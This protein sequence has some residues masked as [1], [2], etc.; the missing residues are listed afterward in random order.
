MRGP[1]LV[2]D[3]P[4]STQRYNANERESA[5]ARRVESNQ[6]LNSSSA[7]AGRSFGEYMLLNELGRGCH[8][9]VYLATREGLE[10]RFAVKVLMASADAESVARFH[11]EAQAASKIDDRGVIGVV[12]VGHVD[13]QH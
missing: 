3:Q 13:D 8:G 11:V 10:R 9:V 4:A 12:D 2:G 5:R 1:T 7:G 6:R